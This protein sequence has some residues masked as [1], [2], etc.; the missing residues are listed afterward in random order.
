VVSPGTSLFTLARIDILRI[1]INVP[2]T[3]APNVRAGQ[4]AQIVLR[5]FPD[6]TFVGTVTRTSRSLDPQTRTMLTE[7]QI[8]NT[9]KILLPG[10]YAQIELKVPRAGQ[11]L[12][13]PASALISDSRG[14]QVGTIGNDHKVHLLPVQVGR[15]YGQ[16]IEIAGG[17]KP[18]DV[19]IT[20]P[21]DATAEGSPA[22]AKLTSEAENS[23]NGGSAASS[24]TGKQGGSG[25]PGGVQNAA[26]PSSPAPNFGQRYGGQDLRPLTPMNAPSSAAPPAASPASP[27]GGKGPNGGDAKT[28]R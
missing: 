19:V 16:Q 27:A 15:D 3:F 7:V 9:E 24:G 26:S 8:R 13:I 20:K 1:Q 6:R 4:K 5:E 10:M 22:T 17:L 11:P 18:D 28:A 23:G 25:K 21:S 2:Q 12:L 14:T